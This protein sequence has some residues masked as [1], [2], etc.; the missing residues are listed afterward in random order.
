M[1]VYIQN[2]SRTIRGLAKDYL[3]TKIR[4]WQKTART[5]ENINM[6]MILYKD[7]EK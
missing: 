5:I 6:R 4:D 2:G 7:L 3:E 1:Y